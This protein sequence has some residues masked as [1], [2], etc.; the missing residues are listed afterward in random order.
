MSLP[1]PDWSNEEEVNSNLRRVEDANGED[2]LTGRIA[3]R[4]APND[5]FDSTLTYFYQKQDVEG[6]SITHYDALSD[7][8]PLSDVIGKYELGL[9]RISICN[10]SIKLRC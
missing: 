6:R 9:C 10:R 1:D 8:N 7:E 5:W 4:W 3:V 2:T